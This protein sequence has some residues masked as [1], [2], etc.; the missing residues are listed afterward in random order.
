MWRALNKNCACEVIEKPEPR[1]GNL[2][3]EPRTWYLNQGL[4]FK[5][6]YHATHKSG[7]VGPIGP[8]RS[9]RTEKFLGWPETDRA[10]RNLGPTRP[11]KG[12]RPARPDPIGPKSV[13]VPGRVGRATSV[14]V[15]DRPG[16]SIPG[17]GGTTVFSVLVNSQL[18]DWAVAAS[19]LHFGA[20]RNA[21]CIVVTG[22]L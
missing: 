7:Q 20:C 4:A 5:A 16:P 21:R 17:P 6:R 10:I 15:Q 11:I 19:G 22:W 3:A 8:T 18:A 12:P 13:S 9:I 1:T 2:E 14:P